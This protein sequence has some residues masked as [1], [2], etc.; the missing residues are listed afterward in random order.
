MRALDFVMAAIGI[1]LVYEAQQR[2]V[3]TRKRAAAV[4]VERA[5]LR[6]GGEVGRS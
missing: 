5:Q 6:L 1:V 4:R 3:E 2:Q